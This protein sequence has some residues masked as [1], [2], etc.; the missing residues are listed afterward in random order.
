MVQG[1]VGLRFTFDVKDPGDPEGRLVMVFG[2]Q[3]GN[4][5]RRSELD[6]GMT[7]I[8]ASVAHFVLLLNVGILD[9]FDGALGR[10]DVR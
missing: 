6:D 10:D 2:S 5:F 3:K 4:D 7:Q 9:D 8:E 1:K